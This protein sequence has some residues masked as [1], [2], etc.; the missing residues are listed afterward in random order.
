M[1]EA[2]VIAIEGFRKTYGEKVLFDGV[3]FSIMAGAK[4]GIVGINGTRAMT[5]FNSRDGGF[6]L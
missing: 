2:M 1:A 3:D 4:V 6:F 5:A